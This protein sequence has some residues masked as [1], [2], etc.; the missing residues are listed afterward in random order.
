M[1]FLSIVVPCFNEEESVGI[2]LEEIQ[3]T[4][5]DCDYEI[6]YINDGSTDNTLNKIKDLSNEN[7]NVK[8]ISFSRN[9]GK[10]AAIFA[11][12]KFAKGDYITLMDADLQH[13]PSLLPQM[14]DT[15]QNEDCD[16]V[17]ARRV[18]RKGEP[19]LK[20]FFSHGFYKFF[21]RISKM[22]LIDGATDYRTMTRQVVDSI[23]EL[24]EYNRFSKGLFEWVGFETRWIEYENVERAAGE[25]TWSFWGLLHYSV[26]G[27]VAFTTAP[28]SISI[29]LG[30][31]FSAIAFIYM[32]IIIVKYLLYSDPV[33]G[34]A[35][36]MCA[37]LFLGGIQL[38]SIGALGTYLGKT[39]K[40]TKNRPIFIVKETNIES[41][42]YEA[43]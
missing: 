22:N 32:I 12:L 33:Q 10:E 24:N 39:Y 27:I 21:N 1:V 36:I 7:S 38:L 5:T 14:L 17:A 35:T 23:L 43:G 41:E 9:F 25:T 8:F 2:F 31:V 37:V 3:K 26:E 29:L 28:L 40:E 30:T 42:E 13:P 16:I 4:L 19:K 6:I 20:S 18:S 15:L 11:G 34:F